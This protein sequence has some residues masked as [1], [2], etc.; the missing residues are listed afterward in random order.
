MKN[1]AFR[2]NPFYRHVE[3]PEFKSNPNAE[4]PISKPMC[5]NM[6]MICKSNGKLWDDSDIS[7]YEMDREMEFMNRKGMTLF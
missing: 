1:N 4:L 2:F 6:D 7:D 5:F 3:F